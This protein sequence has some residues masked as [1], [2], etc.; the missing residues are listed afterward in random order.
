MLEL[1][2]KLLLAHLIADFVLQP[3]KWVE[4]K[5]TKQYKSICLYLHAAIHFV[6]FSVLLCNHFKEYF[7]GIIAITISH[8]IIDLGKS[9]V[10]K[11]GN[12]HNMLFFAID[13]LLHFIVI[14][15]VVL[16]YFPSPLNF[17]MLLS[18]G[19]LLI[20]IAILLATSVSMIIIKLFF[21]KW[22][23]AAVKSA[24][25]EKDEPESLKDA[26]KI[27]GIIERILIIIFINVNMPAGI[28]FLLAAKSVFRFGDLT[29]AK[30]KQLTEYILLGTLMSFTLAILIGYGLKYGLEKI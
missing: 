21:S 18:P 28:G 22:N 20:L 5:K 15:I 7:W 6:V 13:Q 26:G 27:I 23:L 24:E 29:N 12:N 10:E 17:D 4:S 2:L 30:S 16:A 3:G 9:L 8:L 19:I 14:G 25:E 1:T 11:K